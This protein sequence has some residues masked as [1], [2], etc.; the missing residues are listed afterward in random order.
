MDEDIVIS[1]I[2]LIIFIIL[3]IVVAVDAILKLRLLGRVKNWIST[4]GKI[5]DSK[6]I[7]SDVRGGILAFRHRLELCYE[8]WVNEDKYTGNRIGIIKTK[9]ESL[10]R[11]RVEEIEKKY[12]N[13][14]SVN[15]FYDPDNHE[16]ALLDREITSYQYLKLIL[17]ILFGITLVLVSSFFIFSLV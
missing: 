10:I 9:Y 12:V 1:I 17:Q 3:G 7:A 8:Y 4:T 2:F 14:A 5:T 13:N 16:Q 6:I 11:D 15:I